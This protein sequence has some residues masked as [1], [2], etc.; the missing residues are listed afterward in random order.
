MGVITVEFD[1]TLEKSEIVMALNNSSKAEAGDQYSD[2]GLTDKA[3]TSVFGIQ[4]P[5]ISINSTV[6]DAHAV[7]DFRLTSIG[8]L[9]RLSMT[10]TDDLEIINNIDKPSFDNEVRVQILPKFDNAYKKIDL[11]FFISN[12]HVS[13]NLVT[14]SCVYKLSKLT[15]TQ[16]RALGYLDTLQLFSSVAKETGLGFATNIGEMLDGRYTYCDNISMQDL[17]NRE[18]EFANNTTAICDWWVDFW[19]NINLVDIKDRYNNVDSEDELKIWVAGQIN[20]VGA[21][22]PTEPNLMPAVLTTHPGFNNSELF[23][24][25][26]EISVKPNIQFSE[27][28][29]MI[30]SVYNMETGKQRDYLVQD[31][32]VKNDIFY[33]F[34]YLGENYGTYE[35]NNYLVN[36]YLREAFLNKIN[37]EIISVHLQSPLL[38]LMRGHK[39][40]FIRYITN[41]AIENKMSNMEADGL[42]DRE[43]IESNIPLDNFEIEVNSGDGKF[44]LDKTS[45]GQYLILGVE[46]LYSNNEWDYVLKL[47]KPASTKTNILTITQ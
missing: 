24:K 45:S 37:S 13:G 30:Y 27:G 29:D 35:T 32:D 16:Y 10:V 20:E 9:P 11:T 43:N 25:E 40:N 34:K 44:V 1:N 2:G 26:Y 31:G 3:Q 38:A 33:N 14:L 15:S 7:V 8:E 36:G 39:V 41:T 28:T 19:D 18:I 21:N 22:I 47:A 42:I 46:I 5:L 12:I 23:V 6:I 4:V 17:L